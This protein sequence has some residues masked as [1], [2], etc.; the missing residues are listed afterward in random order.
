MILNSSGASITIF[1]RSR[2]PWEPSPPSSPVGSDK[3]HQVSLDQTTAI[4]E[5]SGRTFSAVTLMASGD[6]GD[7]LAN[8][9]VLQCVHQHTLEPSAV[10]VRPAERS[11]HEMCPRYKA[12]A[13]DEANLIQMPPDM[14]STNSCM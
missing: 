5:W 4:Q 1:L 7:D 12:M 3:D 14:L 6:T 10:I 13:L 8:L 11:L 9:W 2:A